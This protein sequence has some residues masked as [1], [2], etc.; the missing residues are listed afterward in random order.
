MS[1]AETLNPTG[2]GRLSNR[3]RLLETMRC[4]GPVGRAELAR[5]MGISVQT[6]SN[7]TEE[8]LEAGLL[9]EAGR[10][11]GGRG[12]PV[13]L[14][15]L[16]AN[17]AFSLGFE[18]RPNGLYAAIVDLAGQNRGVQRLAMPAASPD[19]V[20]TAMADQYQ[21]FC[22]ALPLANRMIGAGVVM[23]GPFGQ[24]GL[25]DS[26]TALSGWSLPGLQAQLEDRLELP[27]TLENDATA[28]ASAEHQMGCGRGLESFAYLYFGT[29]LGLGV[30]S[31]GHPMT[32]AFGNAGEIGH[33]RLNGLDQVL[34]KHL[35]RSSV[36]HHLTQHGIGPQ[37]SAALGALF[38][39]GSP[40]LMSW[41]AEARHALR[42]TIEL[43]ENLFDPATIVLGGAMP[44]EVLQGL[45]APLELPTRTVSNRP[46]RDL[47]RVQVGACGPFTV[48]LGAAALMRNRFFLD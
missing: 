33:L 20:I 11:E 29:G 44:A 39:T 16:A 42:L 46:D 35:S 13:V 24:T 12:L 43:V 7:I 6:V 37:S 5:R 38:D 31:A 47:P 34:E 40:A 1:I 2:S 3:Q 30:I 9:S 27:V 19:A 36:D 4:T 28:G 26:E 10:V 8:L 23:P 17:G 15:D 32:G 45:L 22:R 21:S 41:I 48:S 25:R 18:V 14:Y